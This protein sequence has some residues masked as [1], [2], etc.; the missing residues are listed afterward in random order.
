MTDQISMDAPL[1]LIVFDCDGTLVDSQHAIIAAMKIAWEQEGL[2]EPDDEVV[3]RHVGLPL[4]DAIAGMMGEQ[5]GDHH[6]RMAD[7]YKTAFRTHRIDS[8][9]AS[10]LFP[11]CRDTLD[12]FLTRSYLMGVA[13]G[14]GRRGLDH[15]IETHSLGQYF[16]TLKTADD[17]PGKPNPDILLDAMKETGVDRHNT[18]MVGDTTFDI[19]MARNAGAHAIGVSWGYH[20][21][22]D[23]IAA[24]AH[25]VV[26]SF[27]EL[28]EA[29]EAVWG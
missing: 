27:S 1:K 22:Q 13:T 23:L 14:K 25:R 15:T 11:G 2:G 3:R 4:V 24:G 20:D 17:G 19:E 6:F 18:I 8:V 16:M 29:V 28:P 10:P 7:R 21:R 5:I 9:H 12:H 26:S